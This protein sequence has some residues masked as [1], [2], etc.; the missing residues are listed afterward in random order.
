MVINSDKYMHTHNFY[1][2]SCRQ[3]QFQKGVLLRKGADKLV[4]WRGMSQICWA[5]NLFIVCRPGWGEDF[6]SFYAK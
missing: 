6:Q 3:I 2:K 1:L 4:S 5:E